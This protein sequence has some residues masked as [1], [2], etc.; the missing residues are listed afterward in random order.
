MITWVAAYLV[1]G[2]AML[3]QAGMGIG[4]TS[5]VMMIHRNMTYEL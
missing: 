3:N 2:A 4:L 1:S 5:W